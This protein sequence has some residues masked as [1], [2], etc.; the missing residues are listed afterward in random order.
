MEK[1][2]IEKL[3]NCKTIRSAKTLLIKNGYDIEE[4]RNGY[5]FKI[6][7]KK[8]SVLKDTIV[9]GVKVIGYSR[10]DT[11]FLDRDISNKPMCFG[12]NMN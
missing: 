8:Y 9:G 12:Y 4:V 5:S 1:T 10:W 6:N 11:S 2:F 3:E 7:G